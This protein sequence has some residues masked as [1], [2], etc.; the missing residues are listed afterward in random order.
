M[1]TCARRIWIN[2]VDIPADMTFPAGIIFYANVMKIK[3]LSF[4]ENTLQVVWN[5]QISPM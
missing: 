1:R 5:V 4:P 2:P 3:I